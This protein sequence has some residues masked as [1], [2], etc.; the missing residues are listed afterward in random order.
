MEGAPTPL[1]QG[2]NSSPPCLHC[3]RCRRDHDVTTL[4]RKGSCQVLI[5]RRHCVLA[6][7]AGHVQRSHDR[8][9][10][11]CLGSRPDFLDVGDRRWWR[12]R[13]RCLSGS[14]SRR[15]ILSL[16]WHHLGTRGLGTSIRRNH[17][18]ARRQTLQERQAKHPGIGMAMRSS[19]KQISKQVRR[20][21]VKT[22]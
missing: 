9:R 19:E 6:T 21:R 8:P 17:L 12:W 3:P 10:G 4:R 18:H 5:H 22:N 1:R 2:V 20:N 14:G 7:G 15:H 16:R 11:G 13:D